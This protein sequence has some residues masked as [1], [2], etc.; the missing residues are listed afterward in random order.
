[1]E[2]YKDFFLNGYVLV[3]QPKV[4]SNITSTNCPGMVDSVDFSK[5]HNLFLMTIIALSESQ[6]CLI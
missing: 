6:M 3:S 5:H 4:V 2:C 1:M